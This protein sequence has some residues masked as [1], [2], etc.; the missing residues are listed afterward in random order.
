[1][2]C[3]PVAYVTEPRQLMLPCLFWS[4]LSSPRYVKFGTG[5]PVAALAT[6]SVTGVKFV[7]APGGFIQPH[8]LTKL[9]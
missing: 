2:L 8:W 3:A 5:M 4:R 1:M 7:N 9:E 6:V